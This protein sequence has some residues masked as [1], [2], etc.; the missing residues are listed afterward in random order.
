MCAFMCVCVCVCVCWG[1]S[2]DLAISQI[3]RTYIHTWAHIHK[4][5]THKH[6]D[7]YL[8]SAKRTHEQKA[9]NA[10]LRR[11]LQ[12]NT[13]PA[14]I[15]VTSIRTI[16][17]VL[18]LLVYHKRVLRQTPSSS[19]RVQQQQ[20]QRSRHVLCFDPCICKVPFLPL[21]QEY[22]STKTHLTKQ[23]VT[24]IS[25]FTR[26]LCAFCRRMLRQTPSCSS[27]QTAVGR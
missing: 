5:Y 16:P 23:P 17:L 2:S 13:P 22:S 3:T 27:T 26:W 9:H 24:R 8:Q 25:A 10:L 7:V 18:R 11:F 12:C 15:V 1:E 4:Q 19:S 21:H 14:P 20:Q 6:K